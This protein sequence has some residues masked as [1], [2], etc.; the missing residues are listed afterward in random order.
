MRVKETSDDYRY[1][2]EPDLPP[3]HLDPAWLAA[4]RG[5]LPELPGGAPRA[6]P[7]RRSGCPPTTPRSSSPTR[8]A[9]ALFEATLAAGPDLAG[10]GGRELGH[11]A[12]TCALAERRR[13][14][15]GS[16]VDAAPS[17]PRSSRRSPTGRSPAPNGREVLDERTSRR[18]DAGRRRSSSARGF[19]PDLRQRRAR[20]G[21]RRG[22]RRQPGGRRRL[23]RRQAAGLG[24]LV[25]Q[26]MKATRGQA[27]AALVQA[28]GPRAPR[29][30]DRR[31]AERW[32]SSNIVLWVAGVVLIAV[33]YTR[34]RGP[35][36]ALPG[37]QG[38]GRERR[39]L[40]G[41]A[42]RR[43]RRRQDRAPRSRWQI[44]RRQARIG[45]RDRDRRRRAASSSASSIR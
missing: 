6:L 22:A 41:V 42:R 40:R 25:G 18:G 34:A 9:R 45:R 10:E 12:S 17:W 14:R 15:P 26:V 13:R 23:P 20:R 24:F 2:P 38:P 35:V 3:L 29:P 30:A 5:A 43:P 21:R 11:R 16:P 27:N 4:I 39:P 37:A 8:D 36:G 7:R 44:L 19:A 31:R 33:G 32:G 28:R 1:F